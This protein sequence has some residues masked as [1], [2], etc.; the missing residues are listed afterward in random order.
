MQIEPLVTQPVPEEQKIEGV[1]RPSGYRLLVEILSPDDEEL[2]KKQKRI[3]EMPA[4]V[5]DREWGAMLW[6]KVID[7]GPDAYK[8]ER[9]YPNGAWCRIGDSVLI[10]PYAGTRFMV[11]GKLYALINDDTVQATIERPE[12]LA[13]V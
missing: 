1:L 5:R 12:E 6:G 10:R 4:E 7:M 8:D 13:R 11:F 9:R 3:V 2:R